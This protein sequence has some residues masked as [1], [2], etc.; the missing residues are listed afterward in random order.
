MAYCPRAAV[1][2]NWW[3]GI[4]AYGVAALSTRAV[5]GRGAG[6]A[7]VLGR[8]AAVPRWLLNTALALPLMVLA[9]PLLHALLGVG[10][11][12]RLLTWATPTH[13][14]ARGR[15]PRR[16]RYHEPNTTLTDLQ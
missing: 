1:E 9:Q 8:L 7:A 15:G 13:H 2:V 6:R 12:N 3:L 16:G 11:I 10:W 4:G 14:W 5:L